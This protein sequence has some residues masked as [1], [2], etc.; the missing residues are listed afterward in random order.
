MNKLSERS[1]RLL[2]DIKDSSSPTEYLYDLYN[3]CSSEEKDD[4]RLAISE[5]VDAGCL[6][7]LWA[8]N[9]PWHT[10]IKKIPSNITSD[11]DGKCSMTSTI[12][13]GDNNAISNSIIASNSTIVGSQSSEKSFYE[14]HPVAIGLLITIGG[15][16]LLMFSFWDTIIAT[17]ESM[18]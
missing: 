3:S 12:K 9:S 5:L 11:T 1:K 4:L 13:I 10:T 18:F 2:L 17:I 15:G 7:I 8:D 14:K 6:H 16:L